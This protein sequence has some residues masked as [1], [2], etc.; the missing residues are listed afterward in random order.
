[1]DA[2][3]SKTSGEI[4]GVKWLRNDNEEVIWNTMSGGEGR[5]IDAERSN[6]D[7]NFTQVCSVF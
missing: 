3:S 1:M 6:Q 7:P 2:C 4:I 5:K